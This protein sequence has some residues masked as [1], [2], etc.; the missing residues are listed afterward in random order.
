[1]KIGKNEIGRGHRPYVIAEMSGNH[2]GSLERALSIVDAAA[3]TGAQA[4]KLQ[5]FTADTMALPADK[6]GTTIQDANSPWNGRALHDLYQEAYT[7]WE[8]HQSIMQ[9]AAALGLDCFSSPFDESA[10]DFLESLDC[11]CY[12]IASF[13]AVDIPLIRHAASTGKPLIISTGMAS[14]SE[15]GEAVD[16]ARHAGCTELALLKCTSNYPASPADSNLATI[17]H[18]REMFEC[19]V[20][21]SDHTLGIGVAIASV[22]MGGTIVEKHFT[23][24]RRDGGV[25]SAFSLEPDEFRNLV[26]ESLRAFESIGHVSYGPTAR[27]R[28]PSTRRRSLYIAADLKAGDVLDSSNLRRVRPGSGLP[29]KFYDTLLGKTVARDVQAGTPASWDLFQPPQS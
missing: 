19:E 1:M 27:E 10:V 24:D 17:P 12:K 5:T 20:G 6:G 11:P 23:L 4:L 7:P 25:D 21:L 28:S 16:A 22:A 15:I 9:H 8:W 13:E 3:A 29:P 26:D 14:V 2:N 18:L